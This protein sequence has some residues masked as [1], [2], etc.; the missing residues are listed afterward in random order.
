MPP[1]IVA[2]FLD[3]IILIG[4]LL[5]VIFGKKY[6]NVL[7][8][9]VIVGSISGFLNLIFGYLGF[10]FSSIIASIILVNI[11]YVLSLLIKKK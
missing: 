2:K 9:S 1:E 5:Y 7:I 4:S 10:T 6:L 11:F 3:P 8:Y